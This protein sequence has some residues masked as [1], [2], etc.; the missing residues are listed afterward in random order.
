MQTLSECECCKRT[1]IVDGEIE[2]AGLTCIT[3]HEG[4]VVNCVNQYLLE[5]SFYEH[6]QEN[7]PLEQNERIHE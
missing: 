6:R 5:T 3:Q 2:E 4:F 7:G 1:N